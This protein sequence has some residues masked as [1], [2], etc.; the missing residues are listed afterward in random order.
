MQMT[1]II[2]CVW[3]WKQYVEIPIINDFMPIFYKNTAFHFSFTLQTAA[4]YSATRSKKAE[5][6]EAK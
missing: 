3:Q 2:Y 6:L 4:V 5:R 1:A